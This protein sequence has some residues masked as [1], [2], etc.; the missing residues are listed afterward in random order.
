MDS[1]D[2]RKVTIDMVAEAAGVSKTTV[3]RYLNRKYENI[4]LATRD[5][6]E[7]VINELNYRPNRS[8]QRLKAA[9]TMLIG[10]CIGDVSSPFTGL[11]LKGITGVCEAAG[12]QVL[13]ADSGEDEARELSALEGFLENRVDGLIVNSTGGNEDFL[14]EIN[15]RGVPVAL[16][17]RGLRRD[18]ILDTVS[19]ANEEISAQCLELLKECGYSRVA[20]FTEGNRSIRPRVLRQKGYERSYRSVFPDEEPIVYE[21][22]R[23]NEGACEACL[24]DFR[25][26]YPE[27]RI[28]LISVNGVTAKYVLHAMLNAGFETGYDFGFCTFDDWSWFRLMNSGITAVA[29][30]TEEIGAAAARMLLER[31]SGETDYEAPGRSVNL[32]GTIIVRGSTVPDDASVYDRYEHHLN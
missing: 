25:S 21:F 32:S 29:L 15:R 22:D 4:S 16:A 14:V 2:E 24:K 17:D 13:F 10:C 26:R 28:A 6:I 20:F 12:Y 1:K 11:L 7:S 31:I 3:S 23:K 19:C 18:G 30:Q 9:K 5:R 8:A 27:E